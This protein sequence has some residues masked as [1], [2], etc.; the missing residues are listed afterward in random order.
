MDSAKKQELLRK[1][2]LTA[3]CLIEL[4]KFFEF[5]A[6]TC[7]TQP[8]EFWLL[9]IQ[10]D[11]K[12]CKINLS[13]FDIIKK[14]KFNSPTK[15]L[16]DFLKSRQIIAKMADKNAGLTLMHETWYEKHMIKHL[17]SGPYTEVP[18]DT[19]VQYECIANLHHLCGEHKVDM[20]KWFAGLKETDIRTPMIY[21]MPKIHKTPI[22]L[23][24]IIPSH[25]WYTTKA[26]NIYIK[27]SSPFLKKA[28]T[29]VLMDRFS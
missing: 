20:K 15:R 22:G 7:K 23:R 24:P 12:P 6:N 1:Y 2:H 9:L 27:N 29:W 21:M 18:K 16:E 11:T 4:E 13:L 14:G 3:D 5:L 10:Q 8:E 17:K 25:S 28:G 26:L 19:S